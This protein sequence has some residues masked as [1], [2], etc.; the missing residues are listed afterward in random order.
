MRQLSWRLADSVRLCAVRIR[1]RVGPALSVGLFALSLAALLNCTH[2]AA[3]RLQ[4][5]WVG[6]GVENVDLSQLAMV[7][8][9]ARGLRFEFNGSTA[10]VTVPSERSRTGAFRVLRATDTTVTVGIERPDHQVDVATF[11]LDTARTLRWQ[12]GEGRSIVFRRQD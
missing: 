8:G 1:A 12:I 11:T 4:G 7:T 6:E 10:T 9:W 3:R 2:P 5:E